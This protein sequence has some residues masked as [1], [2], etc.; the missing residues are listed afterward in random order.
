[1]S[2][3][4]HSEVDALL[5]ALVAGPKSVLGQNLVGLYLYGS[6]T[7]GDYDPNVSDVDLLVV[8][9]KDFDNQVFGQ[10]NRSHQALV[11][12]A[13]QWNERL[14]I[15]YVSAEA[16]RNFRSQPHRMAAISPSE[17]FHFKKAEKGWLI[18]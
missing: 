13:P 9:A 17:P 7:T 4:S 2:I 14:E 8:I 3:T 1:M 16:L 18:D 12:A 5:K 6:L 10:L 11:Q 15:A